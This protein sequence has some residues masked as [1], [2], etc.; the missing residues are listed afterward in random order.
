[1]ETRGSFSVLLTRAGAAGDGEVSL[2]IWGPSSP[3]KCTLR[4]YR[5]L[6]GD[7]EG[8]T[9]ATG[10][11]QVF[12]GARKITTGLISPGVIGEYD[13]LSCRSSPGEVQYFR[14]NYDG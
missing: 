13:I 8:N 7:F 14:V 6:S 4:G 5:K 3:F 1:M 9:V 10:Y 12:E 11:K 2:A